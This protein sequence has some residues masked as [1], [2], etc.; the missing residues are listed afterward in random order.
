MKCVEKR[1]ALDAVDEEK[2]EDPRRAFRPLDHSGGNYPEYW[3]DSTD[4]SMVSNAVGF[5]P[6]CVRATA[7]LAPSA[8][9]IE[10]DQMC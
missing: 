5:L 2:Y 4:M 6:G 7:H 10:T 3:V 8:H 1:L 9:V